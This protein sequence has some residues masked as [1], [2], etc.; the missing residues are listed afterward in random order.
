[1]FMGACRGTGNER[2]GVFS[3]ETFHNAKVIP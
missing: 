1:M 3:E 2:F